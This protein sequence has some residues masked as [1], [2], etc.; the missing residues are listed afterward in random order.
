M[1][2]LKLGKL[3]ATRPRW[4]SDLAVYAKG[5]LPSPPASVDPPS[6]PYPMDLNDQ[7]GI[8][9]LA[10]VDHLLAA[11]N[12]EV[13]E[14]DPRP[15]EDALRST[16][17]DL[18]GGEDSGLN[19]SDL[20]ATWRN[21]G[22]WGNK[23][24]AYAPVPVTDIRQQQQAIAFYGGLYLGIQC[25]ASAQEDFAA[26]RP[27]VYDPASPIEGGHCIVGLGFTPTAML[28]ATWGAIAEVTYPF[29]AH[30]LDEAWVVLGNEMVEAKGD[31]LGI[32]LA[33]LEADLPTL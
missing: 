13:H 15:D 31:G 21:S 8:C 19:E 1:S 2:D 32:D 26:K 25:P 11:W 30:M 33:S 22:L 29:L 12:A 10:G 23:I 17:F 27:W 6:V 4:L 20:L 18:T 7:L 28:C 14:N 9:T 5:K 16:Y 24:R 3:D